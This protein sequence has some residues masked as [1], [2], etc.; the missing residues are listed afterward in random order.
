MQS[1]HCARPEVHFSN[2]STSSYI[3]KMFILKAKFTFSLWKIKKGVHFIHT[4]R[5][6]FFLITKNKIS[7]PSKKRFMFF[8]KKE[9][10]FFNRR[11]SRLGVQNPSSR[12]F[13][14]LLSIDKLTCE[15]IGSSIT[16]HEKF[17]KIALQN[18]VRLQKKKEVHV[19]IA[20]GSEKYDMVCREIQLQKRKFTYVILGS[21]QLYK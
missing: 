2:T 14:F 12:R 18:K 20:R 11:S 17:R 19:R 13:T 3:Y 1:S 21:Y 4:S 8:L 6:I 9:V 10:H 7:F 5:F 16:Y 15:L